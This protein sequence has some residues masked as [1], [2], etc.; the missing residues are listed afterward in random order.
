MVGRSRI[1]SRSFSL[2]I[3]VREDLLAFGVFV[4]GIDYFLELL[5]A[6]MFEVADQQVLDAVLGVLGP[7]AAAVLLA[8]GASADV[9]DHLRGQLDHVEGVDGHC[10]VRQH[11]AYGGSVDGA[12]VDDHDLH[13]PPP[14]GAGL[15]QPVSGIVCG[16][17][18]DLAEQALLTVDIDEPGVPPVRQ[19]HAGASVRVPGEPGPAPAGLVDTEHP[20]WSHRNRQHP[21]SVV[22]E[23]LVGRRPRQPAHPRRDRHRR[24]HLSHQRCGLLPQPLSQPHSRRYLGYHLG[25]RLPGTSRVI[26][27]P[28]PLQPYQSA[29]IPTPGQV[30]RTSRHLL[31]HPFRG[32]LTARAH[33]RVWVA[34]HHPY[35]HPPVVLTVHLDNP[36]ALHAQQRRRPIPLHSARSSRRSCL[37]RKVHDLR[38]LRAHP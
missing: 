17:A 11:P 37:S 27:L 25:E 38:R 16:A 4:E 31:M 32:R 7:A 29:W 21:L 9:A 20:H 5:G 15:V 8:D 13:L 24:A 34:G 33:H 35:R 23:G 18:F 19:H 14:G 26:A 1:R 22:G 6:E 28:P 12:H 3:Q 2:A 36:H 10:G 30:T